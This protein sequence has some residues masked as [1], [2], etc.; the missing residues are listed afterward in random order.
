MMHPFHLRVKVQGQ[1]CQIYLQ[2]VKEVYPL[3]SDIKI[4]SGIAGVSAVALL[5][6]REMYGN[7]DA[8]FKS[9]EQAEAVCLALQGTQDGLIILPTGGGNLWSG[10]GL[11]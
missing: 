5:A 11:G 3:N 1:E 10:L 4:D 8:R 9:K 6:L 7:P 2:M